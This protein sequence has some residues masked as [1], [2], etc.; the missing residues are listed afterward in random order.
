ML[1]TPK[2]I[3]PALDRRQH[4]VTYYPPP[5]PPPP[6]RTA[7][8]AFFAPRSGG[9]SP[10]ATIRSMGNRQYPLRTLLIVLAVGPPVMAGL[11]MGGRPLLVVLLGGLIVCLGV[12]F[13]AMAMAWAG[14]TNPP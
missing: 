7:V 1:P 6:P 10:P 9:P 13:L 8:G 14:T 4:L 11:Y 12:L 2:S 5:P 3:P